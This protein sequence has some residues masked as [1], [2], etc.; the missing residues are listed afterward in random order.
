MLFFSI[1]SD[2]WLPVGRNEKNDNFPLASF[3]STENSS[4]DANRERERTNETVR[5]RSLSNN[6][7]SN[8]YCA[9][10][11]RFFLKQQ[12]ISR[13]FAF[14]RFGRAGGIYVAVFKELTE[15]STREGRTTTTIERDTSNCIISCS[16]WNEFET[17]TISQARQQQW[18]FLSPKRLSKVSRENLFASHRRRWNAFFPCFK[19]TGSF[20][21]TCL[22]RFKASD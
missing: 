7:D 20:P 16:F 14:F 3:P 13:H 1:L 5:E 9:V 15:Y 21:N 18:W 4:P 11:R 2:L 22:T 17:K 10:R 8:Q 6:S 12:K 19:R